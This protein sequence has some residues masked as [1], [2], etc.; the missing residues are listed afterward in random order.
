[1]MVDEL[2]DVYIDGAIF[3]TGVDEDSQ[4]T[5]II[6]GWDCEKG[7]GNMAIKQVVSDGDVQFFIDNEMMSRE[8]LKRVLCAIVDKAILSSGEPDA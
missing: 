4:E 2:M 3:T 6:I 1:V 5:T 7:F 8:F